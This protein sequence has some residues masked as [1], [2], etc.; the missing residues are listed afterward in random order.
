MP[1]A[2]RKDAI[3][4]Q[5]NDSAMQMAFGKDGLRDRS[6]ELV[7]AV[8]A[9]H[10]VICILT[11]VY[12]TPDTTPLQ[13]GSVHVQLC[14]Q[15]LNGAFACA[16]IVSIICAGVGVLFLI[17]SHINAY[18]YVLLASA[19]VDIA[20]ICLL[21]T[22]GTSCIDSIPDAELQ[23]V[24]SRCRFTTTGYV[25]VLSAL[26]LFKLFGMA[27]VAKA[28][29]QIRR[30]NCE[31]LLPQLRQALEHAFPSETSVDSASGFDPRGPQGGSYPGSPQSRM[32]DSSFRAYGGQA[33]PS[34][35]SM[36]HGY[37]SIS[38]VWPP[39]SSPPP[40]WRPSSAGILPMLPGTGPTLPGTGPMLP[41]TGPMLPG[42]Q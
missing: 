37:G 34:M 36:S 14:A 39:S 6:S 23:K 11:L 33:P 25:L 5:S 40:R 18:F 4:D 27:V 19:A 16:S 8:C 42:A 12:G 22:H 26:I 15:W 13:L 41:G 29:V 17:E 7:Y 32:S 20:W 3:R 21:V 30:Q 2:V 24:G 10:L 31:E 35:G 1:G 9:A 38:A 28:R